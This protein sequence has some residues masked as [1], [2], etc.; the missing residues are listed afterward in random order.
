MS[1]VVPSNHTRIGAWVN[2]KISGRNPLV[3]CTIPSIT[4]QGYHT[5]TEDTG[6]LGYNLVCYITSRSGWVSLKK[7]IYRERRRRDPGKFMPHDV[8]RNLLRE[9]PWGR[10][11]YFDSCSSLWGRSQPTRGAKK[12]ELLKVVVEPEAQ[13]RTAFRPPPVSCTPNQP[14]RSPS[15]PGT[16]FSSS[17]FLRQKRWLRSFS[18][19]LSQIRRNL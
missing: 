17:N 14:V 2:S 7:G 18:L 16:F 19:F 3:Y 12:R 11:P 6:S 4:M 10:Y 9:C 5:N 15:N 8:C 1:I 13:G